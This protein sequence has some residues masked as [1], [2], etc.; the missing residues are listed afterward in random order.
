MIFHFKKFLILFISL[1]CISSAFAFVTNQGGAYTVSFDSQK[2]VVVNNNIETEFLV[3]LENN[4]DIEQKIEFD[5]QEKSGW[6]IIMDSQEFVLQPGQTE[7]VAFTLRANSNFDYYETVVSSDTI[8]IGK[9]ENYRGYF[10][11]PVDITSSSD[12]VSLVF[13]VEVVAEN[14]LKRNYI[15]R[16]SSKKLSPISP[17]S[18]TV[19]A[20]NISSE[21]DVTITPVLGDISFDK[22][23]TTFSGEDNYKI[24]RVPINSSITPG[25]Y[26]AE[27]VVREETNSGSAQEW[28]STQEV[29]VV[30]YSHI[31]VEK[32]IR[33]G[34]LVDTTQ[35][36]LY[37]EGNVED[38]FEQEINNSFF[39][40]LFFTSTASIDETDSGVIVSTSLERGE[41]KAISYSYNYVGLYI[42]VLV[43]IFIASYIYIRKTSNPFDVE[44]KIYEV[45]RDPHEGVKSLKI[46]LGFENIKLEEI[47]TL[48]V[49]FRMPAY[50]RIREDSFLLTP[51]NHVLKGKT[52]Y[53]LEWNFKRFEKNDSRILG[54]SMINSKGI[55]GDIRFPDL[56]FEIKVHGK[57][58]KYYTSLPTV[59]G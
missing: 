46:R 45:K 16:F 55:L 32:S 23:E 20:L 28:F 18:F 37:N 47:E 25:S 26:I 54:F 57:T 51:P 48:K 24:F 39:S 34:V 4:L 36:I 42:I 8:K 43:I 38:T 33:E 44:T 22:I 3:T 50:L 2:A 21:H 17:F 56:E 52:Q 31:K 27:V 12:D 13:Q 53:K 9:N 29:K 35:L 41:K 10:E 40:G 49:I 30:P 59:K 6:D 7:T 5:F 19:E 11:F 14:D 58:R 15:P 1:L